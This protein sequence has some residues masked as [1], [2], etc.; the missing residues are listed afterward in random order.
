LWRTT[1]DQVFSLSFDPS[2]RL[3][4][5][6]T[7]QGVRIWQKG[8]MDFS[9]PPTSRLFRFASSSSYPV[10]ETYPE[11][12]FRDRDV[13]MEV[14]GSMEPA[15]SAA[16][17]EFRMLAEIPDPMTLQSVA[18]YRDP[19]GELV[20]VAQSFIFTS[21]FGPARLTLFQTNG[22][23]QQVDWPVDRGT[24]IIEEHVRGY[25]AEIVIGGWGYEEADIVDGPPVR[26]WSEDASS[27]FIRWTEGDWSYSVYFDQPFNMGL[28]INSDLRLDLIGL[29]D[30]IETLWTE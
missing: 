17:F 30:L 6:G 22:D 8:E 4:V 23:L 11:N 25:P 5:G 13:S 27:L 28:V 10:A 19:E 15:I 14:F 29:M 21:Y 26:R 24:T 12:W 20:G 9:L 1:Q 2:G 3:L 7:V 18:V 16:G